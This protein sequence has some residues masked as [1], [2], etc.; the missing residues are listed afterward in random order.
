MRKEDS[1]RPK[2]WKVNTHTGSKRKDDDELLGQA[3]DRV[4]KWH[5]QSIAI[6]ALAVKADHTHLYN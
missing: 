1:K 4:L 3:F 5:M 6:A 2:S